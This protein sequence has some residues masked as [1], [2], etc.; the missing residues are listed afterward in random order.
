MLGKS[1]VDGILLD[2]LKYFVSTGTT[3]KE[4][5]IIVIIPQILFS[6]NS[7]LA[8]NQKKQALNP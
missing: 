2:I 5:L 3:K 7:A 8:T 1:N 4:K 6:D